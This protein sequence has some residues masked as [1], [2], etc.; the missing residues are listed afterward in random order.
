[1]Y[2]YP[3][4][5]GRPAYLT[6]RKELL[7]P[8]RDHKDRTSERRANS[9]YHLSPA[10]EVEILCGEDGAPVRANLADLSRGGCYLGTDLD[11][12]VET[13]VTITLKLSGDLVRAQ[14]RVVRAALGKGIAL[15]FTSMAA[16][17]FRVLECW[18]SSFVAKTWLA[19]NRRRAQRVA[20][21]IAVGVSGYNEEG[22]R[23][24]EE[25]HTLVISSY[26]CLVTLSTPV[27]RGQRVVLSNLQTDNTAECIVAHYEA[28][29][30][31]QDVGLAFTG[32]NEHF[33]PISFPP[34]DWSPH[35]P[36]AKQVP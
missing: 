26:G 28:R 23:F 21:Q 18:L 16:E 17:E 35:H 11:L 13:E 2:S 7:H 10:P 27:K 6:D 8:K 31:G 19:A 9:R 34:A 22:A 25:T 5:V 36:D 20:I 30:T 15:E 3:C 1:M 12:P 29:D 24:T 14:A 33:W 32:P 4:N